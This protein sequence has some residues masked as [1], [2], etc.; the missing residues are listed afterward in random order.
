M[1]WELGHRVPQNAKAEF[2]VW[3]TDGSVRR[4][5]FAESLMGGVLHF[6]DCTH[7]MQ[8]VYCH[9][10]NVQAWRMVTPNVL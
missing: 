3:L 2:D 10:L 5:H 6:M 7:P 4:V 8:N 9:D 1:D